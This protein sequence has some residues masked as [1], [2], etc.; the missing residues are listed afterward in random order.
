MLI[1]TLNYRLLPSVFRPP[2]WWSQAGSNRWP[3]ACKAGAL[4]AELWPR[5]RWQK[6]DDWEQIIRIASRWTIKINSSSLLDPN[7]VFCLPSSVFW[8]VGLSRLELP[9]SPLSGVR[10]NQL[11]YRPNTFRRILNAQN[12]KW[13]QFQPAELQN[14]IWKHKTK[15]QKQ[16]WIKTI[17]LAWF[18]RCLLSSVLCLLN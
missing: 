8:M 7:A 2:T 5:S 16:Y 4:P 9:T 1:T 12:R 10:S 11:S 18:K 17:K 3:P 6:T 15:V 13:W 14:H